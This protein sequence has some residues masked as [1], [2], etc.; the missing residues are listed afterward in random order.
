MAY[1][2]DKVVVSLVADNAQFDQASKK[3]ADTFAAATGQISKSAST[4]EVVLDN[5]KRKMADALSAGDTTKANALNAQIAKLEGALGAVTQATGNSRIAMMEWQH[6]GRGMADQFASGAPLAQVFAQHI[7]MI[8]QATA[9]SAGSAGKA[10]GAFAKFASFLGTGW[11]I[12]ATFALVGIIKLIQAHKEEGDALQDALDK[13][14]K[15]AEA[16]KISEEADRIWANSLDGLIERQKKLNDE[17]GKRLQTQSAVDRSELQSAQTDRDRAQE[18]LRKAEER[19][20]KL[21]ER[22]RKESPVKSADPNAPGAPAK[23]AQ[24]VREAQQKVDDLQQALSNASS[25]VARGYSVLAEA[26]AELTSKAADFTAVMKNNIAALI[27]GNPALTGFSK[28]LYSATGALEKAMNDAASAG[29]DFDYLGHKVDDLYKR[30]SLGKIG[31]ATYASEV[32][33]LAKSLED[34]ADAAKKLAQQDPVKLFKQSVIGAEGTGPN[35]LGSSAAGFGQFMPSTWLSYFNRLFPDKA[36]LSEAAKLAYRNVRSVAEAVIDKATDDYV[37]VIKKAGQDVTAANLYAVHLLGSKD[38]AKFFAASAGT[39]T[40]SFLSA[41]VLRGNPFLQGTK[42]EAAAAI[43]K[44]IG[45][46]SGAVS[47]AAVAMRELEQKQLA[48]NLDFAKRSDELDAKIIAAKSD[49]VQDE[50]A[51]AD[52]AEQRIRAEQATL[53]A[54]IEADAAAKKA[55]GLDAATVEAQAKILHEKVA[56]LTGE[57]IATVEL[58]RQAELAKRAHDI[59]DQR[60]EFDIADL[61]ASEQLATSQEQRRRI[62]LELIDLKYQQKVED[63]EYLK[64][65]ALRN[66]KLDEANRIQAQIDH[67]PYEKAAE[68]VGVELSTMAPWQQFLKEIPQDAQ[69]ANEALQSIAVNGIHSI[70]DG[71]GQAGA[72]WIK[73]GGLAGQVIREIISKIITLILY[74]Q[75]ARLFGSGMPTNPFGGNPIV[76]LGPD[77][78]LAPSGGPNITFAPPGLAGGGTGIIGGRGGTDNNLLSL[79]GQPIAWVSK[80]EKLSISNDRAA[81]PWASSQAMVIVGVQANDFFEGKILQVTGPVIAQASTSAAQGGAALARDNLARKSLHRLEY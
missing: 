39:P 45:D 31:P 4:A 17:L 71:L 73:M 81:S 18:E 35:R 26:Q 48:S 29:V 12:A 14:K 51:R 53:D 8:G 32:R 47:Q 60:Y 20:A 6:I 72:A 28:S 15:H 59:A 19:L 7:G 13:L 34:A 44:R 5:L 9:L 76:D 33:K 68:V 30:L 61:K 1:E 43:A 3:S 46:S 22:L 54:Q 41:A 62:E 10:E 70:V 24:D 16:T 79:N 58:Q 78:S 25:R 27:D 80:G 65:Q 49:Q 21:Q 63:L 67:A 55:A 56:Q 52:I 57:K 40:S 74:Q 42:S 64:L 2:A 37:T 23:L 11:G 75:I 36:D 66:N 69:A 38:A 77:I 50:I